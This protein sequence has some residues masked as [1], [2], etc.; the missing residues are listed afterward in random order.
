MST[1]QR[2]ERPHDQ[3]ADVG[4]RYKVLLK[5]YSNLAVRAALTDETFRISL[6]A[7]ESTL[8]KVEANLKNL[9]IEESTVGST[10]FKSKAQQANDN[11]QTTNCEGNKI[12][13]IKLKGRQACGGTSRRRKGALEKA[14]RKRKR[15]TKASSHI[16]QLTPED[17]MGNSNTPSFTDMLNLT[18]ED[19][20]TNLNTPGFTDM[21][22]LTQA[23]LPKVGN[24]RNY[25]DVE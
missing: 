19:S 21:L 25:E 24:Q 3:N 4:S 22:N 15:Q 14:T 13:G 18:Q 12:K 2:S 7:H 1:T 10:H 5:L 16:Q 9:S 11:V 8:N 17:S 20:M 23:Q 6:D